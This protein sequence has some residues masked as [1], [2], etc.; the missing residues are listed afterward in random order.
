[1][2]YILKFNLQKTEGILPNEKEVLSVHPSK[3]YE[4]VIKDAMKFSFNNDNDKLPIVDWKLVDDGKRFLHIKDGKFEGFP[5]P[6]VWLQLE[7]EIDIED[8][9]NWVDALNSDYNLKID[10]INMDEP[11]YFQDHNGYSK[12]ESAE[13]LADEIWDTLQETIADMEDNQSDKLSDDAEITRQRSNDNERIVLT[14]IIKS[15][16]RNFVFT[17]FFESEDD[18]ANF[19]FYNNE[20][21]DSDGCTCTE[22][23][24]MIYTIHSLICRDGE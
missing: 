22:E 3:T 9:D 1:M 24:P 12:V 21:S 7:D 17:W 4:R 18:L 16:D 13:W 20:Y 11:F 6:V 19:E 5:K 8:S 10:G 2:Y 14:V 23:N 15:S